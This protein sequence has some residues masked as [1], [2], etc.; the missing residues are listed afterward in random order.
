MKPNSNALALRPLHAALLLV[1]A[2]T[3]TL[4]AGCTKPDNAAAGDAGATTT[5]AAAPAAA[6]AAADGETFYCNKTRLSR[7][8]ETSE[9]RL[10]EAKKKAESGTDDEKKMAS[11]LSLATFESMC[12][13]GEYGKG[14]CPTAARIGTCIT[15]IGKTIHYSNGED[16]KTKEMFAYEC[17]G[18]DTVEDA[19]GKAVAKPAPL[20]I[21]CNRP[22]EGL[23]EERDYKGKS[24]LVAFCEKGYKT[25]AGQVEM[26]PCATEKVAGACKGVDRE[27][28]G[29]VMKDTNV[30]YAYT[31]KAAA[32]QKSL[33]SAMKKEW[34]AG[35]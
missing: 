8:E 4:S 30:T 23:C 28:Q 24:S 13:K 33:C 32:A 7:C 22:T 3:L 6:A 20:R 25:E 29:H 26:K 10:A 16:P 35:Q 1:G 31:A 2:A 15:P 21:S 14:A 12:G 11:M 9:A 17:K 27:F 5:A 19:D 34:A 18:D